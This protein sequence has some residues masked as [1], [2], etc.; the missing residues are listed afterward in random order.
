M[1]INV[2]ELFL[3]ADSRSELEFNT[4][5]LLYYKVLIHIQ[6]GYS[7]SEVSTIFDG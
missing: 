2:A 6:I 1:R 4:A 3:R 7:S 5:L